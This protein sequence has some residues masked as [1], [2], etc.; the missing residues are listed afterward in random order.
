MR[1]LGFSNGLA[2]VK[3]TAQEIIKKKYTQKH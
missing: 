1:V 3:V 2:T